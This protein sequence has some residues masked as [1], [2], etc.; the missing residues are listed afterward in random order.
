MLVAEEWIERLD[1]KP[2]E[3]EGGYYRETFRSDEILDAD[4]LP[5]RYGSPRPLYTSIYYLLTPDS[6]RDR[7]DSPYDRAIQILKEGIYSTGAMPKRTALIFSLGGRPYDYYVA[8]DFT[9]AFNVIDEFGN[10]CF[11]IFGRGALTIRNPNALMRLNYQAPR[12]EKSRQP[13]KK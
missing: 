5:V 13:I 11:E 9:T 7:L 1:L 6:F 2:L 10:Y 3:I 8:R 12:N 4:A